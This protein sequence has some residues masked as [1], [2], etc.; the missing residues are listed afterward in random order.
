MLFKFVIKPLKSIQSIFFYFPHFFYLYR[1]KD[2]EEGLGRGEETLGLEKMAY[3]EFEQNLYV[4]F[5]IYT[6]FFFLFASSIIIF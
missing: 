5:K 4:P 6:I 2:S 1:G 3:L